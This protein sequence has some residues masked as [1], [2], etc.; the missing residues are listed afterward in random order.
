MTTQYKIIFNFL[1]FQIGWFSCVIFAAKGLP[2]YGIAIA[3]L[4]LI[5]NVI[6]MDNPLKSMRLIIAISLLGVAWDSLLT[7]NNVFVFGS[8]MMLDFL[9]PSW[10]VMMWLIF[11]STI[12]VSFRW[13]FGRYWLAMILGA[14][15]GPLAYF[16][17]AA[18]DAVIINDTL[19]AVILLSAGWAVLM[20]LMMKI[21]QVF[22]QL[23]VEEQSDE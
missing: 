5:A 8:G 18:L 16:S 3:M 9:A 15:F 20:P 7:A 2:E 19:L 1:A 11:S 6:Q 22:E 10:I 4:M 21:A 17:G 13:L 23:N 14:I 12:N